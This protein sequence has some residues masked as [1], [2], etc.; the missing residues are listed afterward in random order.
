MYLKNQIRKQKRR[1]IA[2]IVT[3]ML[4][5]SFGGC[6]DKEKKADTTAVTK[7]NETTTVSQEGTGQSESEFDFSQVYDNIEL[8]GKKI[9][10][11]FTLNDLGEEYDFKWDVVDMGDGLY[12]ADLA[13]NGEKIAIIYIHGESV[14][15]INRNSLVIGLDIFCSRKQVFKI[16]D[17][18]CDSNLLGVNNI[19]ANI[20]KQYNNKNELCGYYASDNKGN[21]FE[22][23]IENDEITMITIRK[24]IK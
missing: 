22:I 3:L 23:A 11:P 21:I 13:Y 16:N 1:G 24:E 5:L 18:N 19:F 20:L 4:A 2:C 10:F 8:N 6:G 14:E 9:P 15:D 7:E 12:S 17:V